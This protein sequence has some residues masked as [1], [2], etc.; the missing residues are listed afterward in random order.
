MKKVKKVIKCLI[1]SA[2]E[3]PVVTTTLCALGCI[4]AWFINK[5]GPLIQW[6]YVIGCLV[7]L[8]FCFKDLLKEIG[9]EDE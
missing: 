2:M 6:L 4:I 5:Q 7:I 1:I 3:S 9:D 8:Y